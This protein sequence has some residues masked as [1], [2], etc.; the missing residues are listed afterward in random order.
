MFKRFFL[1]LDAIVFSGFLALFK[2][3]E[4]C[5]FTQVSLNQP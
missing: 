3:K 4:Q 2:S 5:Q 1:K